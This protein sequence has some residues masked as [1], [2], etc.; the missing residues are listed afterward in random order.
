MKN[1]FEWVMV[2]GTALLMSCQTN[3]KHGQEGNAGTTTSAD[4]PA[5][6][7]LGKYELVQ[8]FKGLKFDAPVELQSPTDGTNR[9]FVVEQKGVIR[10]FDNNDDVQQSAV[11]LDIDNTVES[12]GEKGLLGLAFH[13]DYKSNGFFYVNYTRGNPLET[14]IARYKVS[15]TSSNKADPSSETILMTYRQP[16]GNHN[17][18]KVA[19]GPDGYLYIAAGDGGSGG[20]PGNRA[21]DRK[22]W[23]GKI[24]RI[25]V[26]ATSGSKNYGIPADNPFAGNKNGYLEEI[27]AYGLRNPWRFSFDPQTNMLWAGDV[28]QNKIEEL[29]IIEKGGNYGW[30]IMEADECFKQDKCNKEGLILPITSY[31]QDSSTG[32]SVTGGYVSRDA[33]LPGLN[34]KYIYGDYVSGN[35]WVL[36]YSGK[37]AVSN[38]KIAQISGGLSSFGQDDKNNLYI[39]E[40]GPG[41]VYKLKS[42]STPAKGLVQ[43]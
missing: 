37:K 12:G 9:I 42:T 6:A 43:Q 3:G 2:L 29:D 8:V 24:L 19:F 7:A 4:V 1:N 38:T 5:A 34:G 25:D 35:I 20:D 41:K 30:N 10:V 28:G 31:Q 17:G 22:E 27:Y 18:G 11:F 15:S 14:V 39:L 16:Y 36:N 13:P 33:S 26:N 21:Q 23:L 40:Y 32:R